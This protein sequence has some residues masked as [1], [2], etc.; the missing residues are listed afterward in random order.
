MSLLTAERLTKRFGG[1]VAVNDVSLGVPAGHITSLIGPNGAG[2]TT[3]FNALTGLD[4]PDTGSVTLDGQD[5]TNLETHERARLGMG[6]TFQRLEVFTGMTVRENLQVAAEVRLDKGAWRDAFSFRHRTNTAV[7]K[8]V[9]ATLDRVGIRPLANT[10]AGALPTGSL[11]LVEL[12][13]AL[14]MEP[15]VLLLD[16][17]GSGLDHRETANFQRVLEGVA[18]S[19]VGV[20][21]IEHDVDLVMAVSSWVYVLDFGA[22]IAAGTPDEIR[23]DPKVRAAYLGTPE[24][25]LDAGGA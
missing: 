12:G 11:R 23:D 13:R 3:C 18:E 20:L 10:V 8:L 17:P 25:A 2:K 7:R 24:E 22:L 5:I 4:K 9:D 15:R 6:R 14:C 1:L 19:G 21:L 16:E